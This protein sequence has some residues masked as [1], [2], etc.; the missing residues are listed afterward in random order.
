MDQ[1]WG[2]QWAVGESGRTMRA[3]VGRRGGGPD[4]GGRRRGQGDHG[5]QCGHVRGFGRSG[6]EPKGHGVLARIAAFDFYVVSRRL[7]CPMMIIHI[8]GMRVRSR[9]VIVVVIRVLV[10]A[11]RVYVL[12]RCRS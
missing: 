9:P 1:G 8:H 10:V 4:G 11:V 2:A 3:H 12:Q 7:R 6:D 5:D